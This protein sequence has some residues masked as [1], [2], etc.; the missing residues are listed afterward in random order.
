MD[1]EILNTIFSPENSIISIIKYIGIAI[2]GCLMICLIFRLIFGKNSALNRAIGVAFG[3]LSIY[4]LTAIIY[5]FNPENLSKYLVPLPF[6]KFSGDY[7]YLFSFT[8]SEF[9]LVCSQIVSMVILVLLYNLADSVLPEGKSIIGWFFLRFLTIVVAMIIHYYVTTLTQ[10][11]LPALL[12]TYGPTILL[13]SLAA[14]VL[15]GGLGLF[16]GLVLT[17]INPVFGI[18]GTF[19]FSNKFGKQISKAMLTTALLCAPVAVCDHFGLHIICISAKALPSYIPIL[20][21]LLA[22]WYLIR[23]KL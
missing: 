6:V 3:I 13:V 9:S 16:A 7:L 14:S 20:A 22:L 21:L 12:V 19:F 11:F 17:V 1:F 23:K 15:I 18:L 8:D 2:A 10:S 5:T 4:I